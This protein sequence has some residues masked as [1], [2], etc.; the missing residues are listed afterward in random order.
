MPGTVNVTKSLCLW[1]PH[2]LEGS[3]LLLF[4]LNGHCNKLPPKSVFLCHRLVQLSDLNKGFWLSFVFWVVCFVLFSF[5]C[6]VV[7]G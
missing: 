1:G 5:V 2:A 3:L 6:T 4:L 7:R